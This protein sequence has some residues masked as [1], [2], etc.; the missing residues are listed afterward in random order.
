MPRRR[1]SGPRRSRRRAAS[2]AGRSAVAAPAARRYGGA[3]SRHGRLPGEGELGEMV[4]EQAGEIRRTRPPGARSVVRL[5][6][7]ASLRARAWRTRCSGRSS[8]AS[9]RRA[10]AAARANSSSACS[11]S[12]RPRLVDADEQVDEVDA[13][14]DPGGPGAQAVE[15]IQAAVAA[16]DREPGAQLRRSSSS[17]RSAG[18]ELDEPDVLRRRADPP[19]DAGPSPTPSTRERPGSSPGARPTPRRGRSSRRARR[20]PRAPLS[21]RRQHDAARPRRAR[22]AA[23][24]RSTR[25]TLG[26]PA[27]TSTGT[28]PPTSSTM[29]S[30]SCR[31]S[32]AR[33]LQH[34]AGEPERDDPVRAGLER[35]AH[36]PPLGLEVHGVVSA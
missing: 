20:S 21:R 18:L 35:E 27:P 12:P 2:R 10:S 9:R 19:H 1:R 6:H 17:S 8:T 11:S 5:E 14:H 23:R 15:Q 30:V 34:L 13:G 16:P 33:E 25:A 26:A 4:I 3:L 24:A 22:R 28:A 7:A 36:D 29:T 31:R 32:S